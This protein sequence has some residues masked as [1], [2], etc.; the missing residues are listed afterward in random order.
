MNCCICMLNDLA[1]ADNDS[2]DNDDTESAEVELTQLTSIA[3][4]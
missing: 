1:T 2:G 4:R 3:S